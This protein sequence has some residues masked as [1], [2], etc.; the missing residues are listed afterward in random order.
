[1]PAGLAVIAFGVLVGAVNATVIKAFRCRRLWNSGSGIILES[2][3]LELSS[4]P[5]NGMGSALN[6]FSTVAGRSAVYGGAGGGFHFIGQV[7][8]S[9]SWFGRRVLALGQSR[10]AARLSGI[11]DLGLTYAVYMIS[12]SLSSLV[13][14]LLG[15]Y[16]VAA[17]SVWEPPICSGRWRL[18]C[19]G[20]PSFRRGG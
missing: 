1:M 20:V 9:R 19:L 15:A 10:A 2:G 4:V 12:G 7:V 11:G 14:L 3:Y 18:W 8:L 13:G 6:S 5:S 17:L 16:S